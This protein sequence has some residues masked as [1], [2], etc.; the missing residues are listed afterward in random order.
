LEQRLQS[1]PAVSGQG[2]HG[3]STWPLKL[4]LPSQTSQACGVA[5]VSL[6]PGRQR[7]PSPAA[8]TGSRAH[9]DPSGEVPVLT[10]VPPPA[11]GAVEPLGKRMDC[12][13]STKSNGWRW[14]AGRLKRRKP[15]Q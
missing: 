12:A 14:K 9:I 4:D 10:K 11:M 8:G 5:A 6:G 1:L 3:P 13:P 15:E 2:T 7:G